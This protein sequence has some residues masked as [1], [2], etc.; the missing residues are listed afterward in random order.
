LSDDGGGGGPIPQKPT[1]LSGQ[2]QDVRSKF[3]ASIANPGIILRKVNQDEKPSKSRRN[4]IP[5]N[6]M[7]DLTTK[8]LERRRVMSGKDIGARRVLL[9]LSPRPVAPM[10]PVAPAAPA[11][12]AGPGEII[13]GDNGIPVLIRKDFE[14]E[15]TSASSESSESSDWDY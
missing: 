2:K 7:D 13:V 8:I 10:A 12:A 9:E 14:S 15:S 3:L 1:E 5:E 4:A 6:E 11:T